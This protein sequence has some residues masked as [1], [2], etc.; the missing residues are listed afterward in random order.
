M[1][2]VWELDDIGSEGDVD[3]L[4]LYSRLHAADGGTCS[5]E[6]ARAEGNRQWNSEIRGSRNRRMN[7]RDIGIVLEMMA[8]ARAERE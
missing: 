3:W 2:W 7:Y 4:A 6:K 5:D 8:E 1:P